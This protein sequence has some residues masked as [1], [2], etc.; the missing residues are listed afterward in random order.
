M[1]ILIKEAGAGEAGLICQIGI[2]TYKDHFA[3]IWTEDGLRNYLH[4]HFNSEKLNA[5]LTDNTI[6]YFIASTGNQPIGFIKI[7]LKRPLPCAPFDKGLELEKIYVLKE[8]VGQGSGEA[9]LHF[10]IDFARKLSATFIWL[11]S[12]KTNPK[13]NR[14]YERHGF[15]IE[16]SIEFETD[17]IKPDMWVMRCDTGL[18]G[19]DQ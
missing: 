9:M 2:Q 15:T 3:R 17:K 7:K 8:Y 18:P 11:C 10:V 13:A 12:L 14:F 4:S 16:G 19:P 1:N 5:D 6:K